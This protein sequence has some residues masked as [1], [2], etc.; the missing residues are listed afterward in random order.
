[1]DAGQAQ[2]AYLLDPRA[3]PDGRTVLDL[4][5]TDVSPAAAAEALIALYRA[6]PGLDQVTVAVG[7]R[8]IGACTRAWFARRSGEPLHRLGEADRAGQPGVSTQ[9]EL[10]RFSCEGCDRRAARLTYDDRDLP[11]CPEHGVMELRG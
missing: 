9:F 11:R 1:M 10:L 2:L 8:P 3:H 7:A 4:P 6:D 5:G